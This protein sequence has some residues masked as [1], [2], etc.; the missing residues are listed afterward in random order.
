VNRSNG[1][2]AAAVSQAE[3]PVSCQSRAK[4]LLQIHKTFELNGITLNGKTAL[5]EW[6]AWQ[7]QP[8]TREEINALDWG[9][10]SAF[11]LIN[12]IGNLHNLD[13]DKCERSIIDAFMRDV[14]LDPEAYP[15]F[16]ESLS[17]NG[18][19]VWFLCEGEIPENLFGTHDAD[20]SKAV[21]KS[22]DGSFDQ[23][24][25]RWHSNYTGV[26]GSA[27]ARKWNTGKAPETAPATI[28]VD[29]IA[30]A[31]LK[32][33][34][35]FTP[36][37]RREF[38]VAIEEAKGRPGDIYNAT[39]HEHFRDTYLKH[40][41]HEMGARGKNVRLRKPGSTDEHHHATFDGEWFY[42]FSTNA[43][44]FKAEQHYSKFAAYALMAH[45]DSEKPYHEA[46]KALAADDFTASGAALP[47]L[48]RNTKPRNMR[49]RAPGRKHESLVDG[50]LFLSTHAL[51]Y[52][53]PGSFKTFLS[54]H[55]CGCVA[56]GLDFFGR[57]VKQGL[58][59]LVAGEGA[60]VLD[61]R[62]QAWQGKFGATDNLYVYEEA[63]QLAN[64]KHYDTLIATIE[65]S[66]AGSHLPLRLIVL[67][68]LSEMTLGI[69]EN[70]TDVQTFNNACRRLA[71]HFGCVVLVIH[72]TGKARGNGPRGSSSIT[73]SFSSNIEVS[74]VSRLPL[75][76]RFHSG[77]IRG[78]MEFDDFLVEGEPTAIPDAAELELEQKLS[79]TFK[80]ASDAA[81]ME[82][83]TYGE[84]R[85]ALHVLETIIER[86]ALQDAGVPK[87][88]WFSE[89][90]NRRV[91]STPPKSA[92]KSTF[93][94]FKSD[95]ISIGKVRVEG[96]TTKTRYF[97]TAP[98][99]ESR[100]ASDE[101]DD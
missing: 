79:L 86:D 40:G 66:T 71:E 74:P 78:A 17:G 89:W 99:L 34:E 48:E 56:T 91:E 60:E 42:V 6:G 39:G 88:Y 61:D 16:E 45:G 36:N 9:H 68:N 76:V 46:A 24:E 8:Q 37:T 22:L 10:S 85:E 5:D 29:T 101:E 11:A 12:G 83:L 15:W 100:P 63:P 80:I 95:L 4:Y 57:P 81:P 77:R 41:W 21:G 58:A 67:D 32:Y 90:K 23:I 30:A 14:G 28:A 38:P 26:A 13:F 82:T 53:D 55:L 73:G 1:S 69:N 98:M 33:C 93:D 27:F 50:M 70:S 25:V 54:L 75:L 2:A 62:F 59:F 19:H 7:D 3:R 64:P 65:E 84:A 96:V 97:L 18:G 35:P 49:H 87:D 31:F 72:H 94:R 20:I 43:E 47:E 44:P 51:L 52:G 92:S